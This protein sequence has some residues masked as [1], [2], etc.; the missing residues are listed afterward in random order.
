MFVL[1]FSLAISVPWFLY[2]MNSV[3]IA[4]TFL[5]TENKFP[6]VIDCPYCFE[7]IGL[8]DDERNKKIAICPSCAATISKQT[9]AT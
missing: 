2:L 5:L 8:E 1:I 3:R 4:N 9:V 6:K 7:R